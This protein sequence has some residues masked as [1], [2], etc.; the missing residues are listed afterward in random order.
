MPSFSNKKKKESSHTSAPLT[1][2]QRKMFL[3]L[4]IL[5]PFLFLICLEI[6]LRIFHYGNEYDLVKKT[7]VNGKE[8]YTIN[9][10]VGKRYFDPAR[11]FVPQ[12]YSGNF[13]I[14]KRQNTFRVFVLGESTPAGF[15]YQYNATPTRVLQKQLEIL[16]PEKNIEIINVGL[17][18]TNSYTVLEFIDELVRYQPN[19]FIVYS[20]QNEFYG[21]FGVAST[22]SIGSERWLIRFYQSLRTVKTFILVENLFSSISH[23]LFDSNASA[24]SGTLMQQLANDK[25]IPIKSS[26][27]TNAMKVFEKNMAQ[28]VQIAVEHNV[29]IILS[30]LVTNERSLPPF[31]SLHNGSLS[32]GTKKEIEANLAVAYALQQNKRFPEAIESYKQIITLDPDYAIAQFRLGQSYDEMKKYDSASIAFGKA[33]DGDGLRFRASS[34]ANTIIRRIAA[35]NNFRIA[36]VES[37]FRAHSANG[38]I[39]S[40]LLWE[41]VHP[42]FTGYVLLAKTWLEGVKRSRA[43][44][45]DEQQRS[46]RT[47]PDSVL[48]DR[49]K[50]TALDLEIGSLTMRGLLRRWP[51]TTEPYSEVTPQNSVKK[52]AQ[53]FVQGKL[54]WN[55]AHYEMAEAYLNEKDVVNALNEYESVIAFYPADPFPLIRMGDLFSEVQEQEQAA[56]AY[57]RALTL[58]ENS[59]VRLKL[60]IIYLKGQFYDNAIEQLSNAI[61]SA[62][63]SQ[64]PL[65]QAQHND[66]QFYFAVALFKSGKLDEAETVVTTMLQLDPGNAK[67]MRLSQEIRSYRELKK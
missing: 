40:S 22:N 21:A 57:V 13:E 35:S 36:D 15:P 47:I 4:T 7:V 29:P 2:Q 41:H 45:S 51:F 27:Y 42:T 18:G 20:G 32:N 46:Q 49:L 50:I 25:A 34:E 44:S 26:S 63:L 1:P 38:I 55:E 65:T 24:Y 8:W 54:R 53:S 5:F 28:I 37:T 48:V 66:A 61:D 60:G 23:V 3:I 56:T 6:G 12:I 31:V 30:T 59:F 19:A 16:F 64:V 39:G 67:A 17:T 9:P 33:R 11:Y 58:H 62:K 14:V 52:V 43:L 10:I